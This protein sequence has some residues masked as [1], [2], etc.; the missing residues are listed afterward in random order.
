MIGVI[1]AGAAAIA[2]FLLLTR[3]RART[4]LRGLVGGGARTESAALSGGGA[5]T[6]ERTESG[7]ADAQ[8]EDPHRAIA[9]IDR[10]AA[11]LRIGQIGRAHV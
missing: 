8:L 10:A 11:L 4:R 9:V 3:S 1:L 2:G 5:Q 7:G 6:G